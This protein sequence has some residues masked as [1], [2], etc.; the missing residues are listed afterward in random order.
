MFTAGDLGEESGEVDSI[1]FVADQLDA[2]C[3]R[4]VFFPAVTFDFVA[5]FAGVSECY[6]Y[7]ISV[8]VL[9]R[10]V[11]KCEVGG[12]RNTYNVVHLNNSLLY[13]TSILLQNSLVSLV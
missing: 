1:L 2:A 5:L 12:E 3:A 8:F 6:R 9:L 4:I 11:D 7:P 13:S 10:D